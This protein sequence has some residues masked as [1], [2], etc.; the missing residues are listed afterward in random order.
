MPKIHFQGRMNAF[1]TT[2]E[3]FYVFFLGYMH[4]WFFSPLFL[5]GMY[6]N[7]MVGGGGKHRKLQAHHRQ[8]KNPPKPKKNPTKNLK[9][10]KNPPQKCQQ[11]KTE[12]MWTMGVRDTESEFWSHLLLALWVFKLFNLSEP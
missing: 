5:G 3:I 1:P 7:N 2:C 6:S 12:G 8:T 11:F 10:Q 4:K 9:Q